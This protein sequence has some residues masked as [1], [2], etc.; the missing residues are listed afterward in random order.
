MPKRRGGERHLGGPG[1]PAKKWKAT[2]LDADLLT[3]FEAAGG[4]MIEEVE[5]AGLTFGDGRTESIFEAPERPESTETRQKKKRPTTQQ[6]ARAARK[7][8]KRNAAKK[9]VQPDTEVAEAATDPKKIVGSDDFV[10]EQTVSQQPA[11]LSKEGEA[12][13]G[14]DEEVSTVGY[15]E[16]SAFELHPALM[17]NIMRLGF[18]SPTQVQAR[19]LLPAVRQRKDMVG[20]AET[21]SGKTLAFALPIL[22]HILEALGSAKVVDD[23][24]LTALAI[25]PTRELAVQVRNHIEAVTRGTPVNVECMVG[26]M[27]VQK[28]H[29]LL[30]RRPQV[31]VGTPGR[32]FALL[33]LGSE[34]DTEKCVW[35]REGLPGLRHLVLDEA[36]RLV[37]SGHFKELDSILHLVYEAVHVGQLQTFI[38]SAT[39]TLDPRSARHKERDGED[40]SKVSMLMRRLR[41]RE[42]RAVHLVDLTRP[43]DGRTGAEIIAASSGTRLPEHLHFGE[44]MCSDKKDMESHLIMWLLMRYR[45]A[46]DPGLS[47]MVAGSAKATPVV[48]HGKEIVPGGRIVVFVNAISYVMRLA[49]IVAVLLESPTAKTVLGKV[50]L[51]TSQ[52]GGEPPGGCVQVLGLHSK[53]R[54][55]DRL[56]RMETFRKSTSAVLICS[57]IAARGLDVPN[58]EVVVHYQAP[59]S[60]DVFVHRSGRTARA[61]RVGQSVAFV[62]PDNIKDWNRIYR[63]VGIDKGSRV[64]TF[65][66]TAFDIT[67]AKDAAK[68]AVELENKVHKI[69]RTNQEKTWMRRIADEADIAYDDD[70]QD[71]EVGKDAAPRKAL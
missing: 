10:F 29:R 50:Q 31:V 9:G 65:P 12:E 70:D 20:A 53:M 26:G 41:F 64:Q 23:K 66:F 1:P 58:V 24:K 28:Q 67:A 63:S 44:V 2:Q 30:K 36:D 14:P 38:F 22:H 56:K 60:A 6:K 16:W 52:A 42:A 49:P 45:W 39:L 21:G 40:N 3:A 54:Q 71:K 32:I 43:E 33:G 11:E 51:S 46:A 8:E 25:L 17:K 37:E 5:E 34:A 61:G 55:K 57:D 19:C 4:M 47:G 59:R 69:A 15:E 7:K 27:A 68:L 35:F 48:K 62:G 18:K 13:G